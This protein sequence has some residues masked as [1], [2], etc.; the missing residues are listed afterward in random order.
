MLI[1]D[2]ITQ[3]DESQSVVDIEN[4]HDELTSGES[5]DLRNVSS[6]PMES[7]HEFTDDVA[8]VSVGKKISSFIYTL[9]IF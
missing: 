1:S 8:P 2:D 4:P 5:S 3:D 7:Q 9:M 6:E